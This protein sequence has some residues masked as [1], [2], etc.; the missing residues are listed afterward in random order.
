MQNNKLIVLD[1]EISTKKINDKDYLSITDMIKSKDG[2]FFIKDWLRN[3]NTLEFLGIWEELHNPNFN[4]GEFAL[5]KNE[6]GVNR[7][8]ISIKE[9]VERTNAIGLQSVAGRYGGSYAHLD[10]AYEFAMWISPKFKVYLINEFQRLKNKEE[11]NLKWNIKRE[12]TKTNYKIHT[13]AIKRN[14]IPKEL[15]KEK[16]NKIYADEADVLNVALFGLTASEWRKNNSNLSG[17]IRDY[18]TL[19]ELICLSNLESINSVM[20]DDDIKQKNRLI[21]LNKIAINQLTILEKVD[22]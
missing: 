2:D 11:K 19:N 8:K 14:L 1:R 21:K 20:I 6:A 10:I 9:W 5:I 22:K 7:F 15:T 17:N 18:A 16:I 3:K 12:L 13:E 4:W